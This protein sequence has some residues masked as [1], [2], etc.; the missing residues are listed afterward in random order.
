MSARVCFVLGGFYEDSYGGAE[1]QAY[2]LA[3]GLAKKGFDVHYVSPKEK[4]AKEA[5]RPESHTRSFTRHSIKNQHYRF[6]GRLFFLNLFDLTKKLRDI[7]PDVIY[8]RSGSAHAGI[9]ARYAAKYNKKVIWAASSVKDCRRSS[10]CQES[11]NPLASFL[12]LINKSMAIYGIRKADIVIAQ[13]FD[14]QALL[15]EEFG[16]ESVV[17]PNAHP[18]PKD[19]F[20]KD[21]PPIIVWIANI[22]PLKRPEIFV[23]LAQTCPDLPARFLMAG[24]EGNPKYHTR[25][26][27][28]VGAAPN[29]DY[30]GQLPLDE[31][32]KLMEKASVL[33]ST[34]LPVEGFPNTFIQAWM[35]RVPTVSLAF[36]PDKTIKREEIG[37]CPADFDELIGNVKELILNENLRN[38]MGAR[39]REYAVG[40]LDVEIILPRYVALLEDLLGA[41]SRK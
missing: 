23:R 5:G 13:T 21:K 20:K 24:K 40:N 10:I 12:N 28:L 25:I 31:V 18:V 11:R 33:V 38:T 16:V 1:L 35:R 30:L 15:K 22:K 37:F 17:I 34:S 19:E 36:D 39:A 6:L 41:D 32:N 9:A 2:M 8:L 29:L 27:A 7:N 26:M 4:A 3:D 14:Q